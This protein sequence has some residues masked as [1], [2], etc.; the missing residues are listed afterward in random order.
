MEGAGMVKASLHGVDAS[1]ASFRGTRIKG[2]SLFR[3]D[4]RGA[5]LPPPVRWTTPSPLSF[6][7]RARRSG[8]SAR[9]C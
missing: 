8:N 4:L 9:T 6:A 3:V 1:G 7:P 2:A 5:D